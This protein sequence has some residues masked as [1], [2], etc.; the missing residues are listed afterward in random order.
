MQLIV[1]P[2]T[3]TRGSIKGN[4]AWEDMRGRQGMKSYGVED[5]IIAIRLVQLWRLTCSRTSLKISIMSKEEAKKTPQSS[6]KS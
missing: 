4:E 2:Q 6:Q 3:L 5:D 1:M